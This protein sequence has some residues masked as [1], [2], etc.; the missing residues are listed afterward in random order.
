[1]Q[2]VSST[3]LLSVSVV[4]ARR[5]WLFS[6]PTQLLVWL[7]VSGKMADTGG[8]SV[9][10][11]IYRHLLSASHCA[12]GLPLGRRSHITFPLLARYSVS[13][14]TMMPESPGGK[15]R[16]PSEDAF[17]VTPRRAIVKFPLVHVKS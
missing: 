12:G 2:M 4:R 8:E 15:P 10:A 9:S 16:G 7:G 3:R 17:I 13:P 1:M 11:V 5:S 14:I 6:R